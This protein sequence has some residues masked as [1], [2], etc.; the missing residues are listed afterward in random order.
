MLLPTVLFLWVQWL[1]PFHAVPAREGWLD[2]WLADLVP[3]LMLVGFLSAPLLGT[4]LFLADQTRCRFRFLAEHGIRPRLVWLSRHVRGLAVMLLGLLLALPPVMGMAAKE[5]PPQPMLAFECLVGFAVLAYACG[6]LCSMIFRRGVM[7]AAFGTVLTFLLCAWAG[8]TYNWLDLSWLW[9]V[10]PLPLAFLVGTWLHAPNWL[11]ERKTWRA[12]LRPVLVVAVPA[13]AILVAIPLVRVY[14][15][16]LVGP[17]FD[18]AELNRPVSAEEKE[19]LALYKRANGLLWQAA[20]EQGEAAEAEIISPSAAAESARRKAVEQAVTLALEASRRPVPA[21]Y[22]DPVAMPNP[23]AEIELANLVLASGK[24]LQTEGKLD[25]ALDRCLAAVRIAI[26]VRRQSLY[27]PESADDLEVLACEQLAG[28]AAQSGQ[29]PRRVLEALRTL[30][31]QWRD[32]PSYRDLIKHK[33]FCD[34]DCIQGDQPGGLGESVFWWLPWERARA[35]RLLNKLTAEQY[36]RYKKTEETLAAGGFVALPS[37]VEGSPRDITYQIVRPMVGLY[38]ID[39]VNGRRVNIGYLGNCL[40]VETY[41][42]ATRLVLALDAWNL[43]HSGLP[44]SLDDLKGKYLD[45]LPVDP[46][47][48]GE[49]Q[50]ESKGFPDY[51]VWRTRYTA[52]TTLQPHRPFLACDTWSTTYGT[53]STGRKRREGGTGDGS[54][55]TKLWENVWVFPIP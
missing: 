2:Y 10:A 54:P 20:P 55:E 3:P 12:R 26:A 29:K 27:S 40:R 19:T 15:I 21:P 43:E 34:L 33:Y 36:A 38:T 37:D 28:W 48:G 17:G 47:S 46:Y 30:E 13:L 9:S 51:I 25:A 7:A 50:Y 52:E 5:H 16:P 41:R 8:I 11:S 22:W 31:Q 49:F 35:L 24:R 4:T 44:E 6:Q 14:E 18:V 45:Q 53:G 1:V 32:P 42:R 23:D 39:V